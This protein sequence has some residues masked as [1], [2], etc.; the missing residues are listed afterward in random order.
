MYNGIILDVLCGELMKIGVWHLRD[1]LRMAIIQ[2][3]PWAAVTL[4]FK[5][6]L[7]ELDVAFR[8]IQS[9]R[10]TSEQ[11]FKPLNHVQMVVGSPGILGSKVHPTASS[12]YNLGLPGTCF[13]DPIYIRHNLIPK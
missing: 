3:Y 6:L 2:G 9:N 7:A 4:A 11:L 8:E 5:P 10:L 1:G 12:S 13:R